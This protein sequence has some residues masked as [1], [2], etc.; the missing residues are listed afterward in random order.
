MEKL[1]IIRNYYSQRVTSVYREGVFDWKVNA[2]GQPICMNCGCV[3]SDVNK[4]LRTY[5]S[6]KCQAEYLEKVY[7]DWRRVQKTVFGHD[8]W[9]CRQCGTDIYDLDRIL[10]APKSIR[11]SLVVNA[12]C[13]HIVPLWMGGKDWH[14][15]LPELHNFQS[16]CKECHTYKTRMELKTKTKKNQLIKSGIQ[17]QLEGLA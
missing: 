4:R 8:G 1:V 6:G 11:Y 7:W 17:K 16:L 14:E 15:D 5:C 9:K 2:K 13:D 10:D 3:L 12:Q